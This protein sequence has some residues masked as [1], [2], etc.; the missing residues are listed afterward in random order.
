MVSIL[1]D[2]ALVKAIGKQRPYKQGIVKINHL[3]TYT[4]QQYYIW[5]ADTVNK[6]ALCESLGASVTKNCW[7]P[8]LN[9]WMYTCWAC[10]NAIDP[11]FKFNSTLYYLADSTDL[12]C[13]CRLLQSRV[14]LG[15][16]S[17]C[18]PVLGSFHYN[19]E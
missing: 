2:N 3:I 4:L 15:V 18:H 14:A 13:T 16:E 7:E 11:E 10:K 6:R 17:F 9:R 12:K 19:Y 8:D 1:H 5:D